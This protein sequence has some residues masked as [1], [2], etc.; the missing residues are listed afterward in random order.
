MPEEASRFSC[1]PSEGQG[2][3]IRARPQCTLPS[4]ASVRRGRQQGGGGLRSSRAK[5]TPPCVAQVE[6]EAVN[7]G[8][9][10]VEG[11]G[12]IGTKPVLFSA[13]P[14]VHAS[15]RCSGEGW[16]AGREVGAA[17]PGNGA[18]TLRA[19]H[20]PPPQPA[21]QTLSHP[22]PPHP[23]NLL[24][25]VRIVCRSW[26]PARRACPRSLMAPGI[27]PSHMPARSRPP[28]LCW[29]A[30]ASRCCPESGGSSPCRRRSRRGQGACSHPPRAKGVGFH[31]RRAKGMGLRT[32]RRKGMGSHPRMA[33]GMC[34]RPRR[35]K[36]VGS[37]TCRGPGCTPL[38]LNLAWGALQQGRLGGRPQECPVACLGERQVGWQGAWRVELGVGWQ[39]ACQG[40]RWVGWGAPWRGG[41]RGV[42]GRGLALPQ[43]CTE[44]CRWG[45]SSTG[46][47]WTA[48]SPTAS[49]LE[50]SLTS[51]FLTACELS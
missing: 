35:A 43:M 29:A 51:P 27:S 6:P 1:Q 33:M 46:T 40:E 23:P 20:A 28:T 4:A 41:W 34:S 26:L 7:S 31:R 11:L 38:A 37:R 15:T 17:G 48:P 22:N 19:A 16:S 50:V 5:C 3:C 49:N 18:H 44:C 36:G 45:S 2:W 14:A 12:A 9:V 24:R 25:Q 10:G 13:Q 39:G 47:T 30:V 32:R 21:S 8:E 42:R